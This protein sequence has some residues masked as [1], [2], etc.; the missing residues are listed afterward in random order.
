M[1]LN[2]GDKAP[3]FHLPDQDGNMH[4]LKDYAGKWLLIYFYPKD[5]TPGCTKEACGLRDGMPDFGK[6]GMEVLGVSKDSEASH[7]KFIAKYDLNF[8]LLAD[9][10][11]KMMQAY[12]AWGEKSMFG[13]K[14]MGTMRNSYLIDPE[15]KIAKIYEKVKPAQHADQVM[16]DLQNLQA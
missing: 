7:Q 10:D 13:N 15:G 2:V 6:L 4:T 3:D 8:S 14:Y 9:T 11:T 12:D 5:S 1:K 16:K